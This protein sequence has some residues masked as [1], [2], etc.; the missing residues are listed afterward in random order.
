MESVALW[1]QLSVPRNVVDRG[2]QRMRWA[3]RIL[4]LA[5]L[6]ASMGALLMVIA[7]LFIFAL[8]SPLEMKAA[9]VPTMAQETLSAK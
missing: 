7:G 4:L 2:K 9:G 5:G 1:L 6:L 3:K 8:Q